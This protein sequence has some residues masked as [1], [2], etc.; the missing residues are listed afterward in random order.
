M[1][2]MDTA[3]ASMVELMRKPSSTAFGGGGSPF[4]DPAYRDESYAVAHALREAG[5]ALQYPRTAPTVFF[6][7]NVQL[8][9]MGRD[10]IALA[11]DIERASDTRE[12]AALQRMLSRIQTIET[13]SRNATTEFEIARRRIMSAAGP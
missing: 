1:A 8:A 10:L 3:L 2:Q 6:Q 5:Y 7:D 12:P 13:R 11:T 4:Y 9:T